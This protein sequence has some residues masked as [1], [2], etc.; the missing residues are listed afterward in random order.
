MKQRIFTAIVACLIPVIA[1]GQVNIKP[2]PSTPVTVTNDAANPVPVTGAV[3]GSIT[4]TVGL[5]PGTGVFIDNT[6]NDPVRV[7][8]VNDA[9]QP[10]QASKPL[11]I[12]DTSLGIQSVLY[13]VPSGKRLVIEYGSLD[14]GCALPG[15]TFTLS[16]A[17]NLGGTLVGHSLGATLPTAPPGTSNIA[18]NGV[19]A[20]STTAMGQKSR[21]YADPGTEVSLTVNRSNRTGVAAIEVAIAGYLVDVPLSP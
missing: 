11:T 13:K 21:L 1:L 18:C 14:V 20:S 3:T 2:A 6:S 10:V 15:Q 9:I 17:T 5:A 12:D 4:G 19:L 7:R 16:L 8:N